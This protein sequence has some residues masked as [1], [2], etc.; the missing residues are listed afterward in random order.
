MKRMHTIT[1]PHRRRRIFVRVA[2]DEL[3]RLRADARDK[4]ITLSEL[5][6]RRALAD[7]SHHGPGGGDEA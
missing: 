2:P 6:R 7:G 5:I 4:R 1:A 3:D